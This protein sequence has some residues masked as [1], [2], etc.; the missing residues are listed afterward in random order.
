MSSLGAVHALAVG[1]EVDYLP[2]GGDLWAPAR[3]EA[4]ADNGSTLFVRFVASD[5]DVTHVVD[6]RHECDSYRIAPA[7]ELG[8]S[9]AG[10]L[11]VSITTQPNPHPHVWL[12]AS[13]PLLRCLFPAGTHSVPLLDGQAIDILRR[14]EQN[15]SLGAS[16]QWQRCE[17]VLRGAGPR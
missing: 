12:T 14:T 1:D 3:V 16:E 4:V 15:A 17:Y 2:F 13:C 5:A 11:R 7:G 10:H 6:L 9:V 8:G